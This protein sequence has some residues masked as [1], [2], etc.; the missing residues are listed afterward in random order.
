MA[1]V[2]SQQL[3]RQL[4][5]KLACSALLAIFLCATVLLSEAVHQNWTTL[6]NKLVH[7]DFLSRLFTTRRSKRVEA[8]VLASLLG[9]GSETVAKHSIPEMEAIPKG[10]EVIQQQLE[11]ALARIEQNV[12]KNKDLAKRISRSPRAIRTIKDLE[13]AI[14]T[15]TLVKPSP[16]YEISR[17]TTRNKRWR[18]TP[19]QHPVPTQDLPL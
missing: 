17:Y 11:Q 19:A 10:M 16:E 13:A 5:P 12:Q 7:P 8:A 6:Y 15:F 14:A 3:A 4:F 9:Q 2:H 1:T 18:C